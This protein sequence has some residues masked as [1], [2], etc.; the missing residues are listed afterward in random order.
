MKNQPVVIKVGGSLLG[1]RRLHEELAEFLDGLDTH[2]VVLLTGGGPAVKA[3]HRLSKSL[4]FTEVE[5]H[6]HCI[7]LMSD[8]T[9][10]LS[11][12]YPNSVAVTTWAEVVSAWEADRIPWFVVE[13]YLRSDD[14]AP[15]HLPHN[16]EVSSDSIAAH[17]AFRHGAELIL[18][19]A[20]ELP[21]KKASAKALA[22]KGI[23]DAWFPKIAD[24]VISWSISNLP[25]GTVPEISLDLAESKRSGRS[26]RKPAPA[27][28][29]RRAAP[30]AAKAKRRK[31]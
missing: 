28:R 1:L 25:G 30:V 7:D 14:Q 20:C 3:L 29:S 4:P 22:K 11:E 24:E 15:D 31:K 19:K 13:S 5:A 23:V 17:L 10:S 2:Q 26:P 21:K 12:T 18:L 9:H 16:W 8:L 6:W 27:P